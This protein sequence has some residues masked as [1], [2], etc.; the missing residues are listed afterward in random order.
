MHKGVKKGNGKRCVIQDYED[1]ADV[2]LPNRIAPRQAAAW[3]ED[4]WKFDIE[5]LDVLGRPQTNVG[6]RKGEAKEIHSKIVIHSMPGEEEDIRKLID[7]T[8]SVEDLRK[9]TQN[10]E[11]VVIT[12]PLTKLG[13]CLP[14]E[15]RIR[16]DRMKGKTGDT[17]RHEETHALRYHDEDR[18]GALT[19]SAFKQRD[20]IPHEGTAADASIRNIEE[21]CTVA[22]TMASVKDVSS[23]GYYG[24]VPVFDE[25]TRRWRAPTPAES[26]AMA[27]EDRMLF[28]YGKDKPLSTDDAVRSVNENFRR[29]NIARLRFS[30]R[31]MAINDLAKMEKNIDPISSKDMRPKGEVPAMALIHDAPP[32]TETGAVSSF[33][34]RLFRRK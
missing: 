32:T 27:M 18:S 21:A 2:V 6:K 31:T 3:W 17:M 20:R 8:Y 1:R 24:Y 30:G 14:V 9:L 13:D 28:T 19:V 10:G 22:E 29:S 25:K 34:G 11:L 12:Q 16:L 5:G 26:A 23:I 7:E 33:I 4:P 15:N